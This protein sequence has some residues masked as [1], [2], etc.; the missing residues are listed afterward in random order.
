[1]NAARRLASA[2]LLSAFACL[3]V[4]ESI[5][6]HAHPL[7]DS[8]LTPH[9]LALVERTATCAPAAHFDAGRLGDHPVC[10]ECV[11]AASSIA[12]A[13]S[14]LALRPA[15]ASGRLTGSSPATMAGAA[16]THVD[17]ARGPPSA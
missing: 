6:F 5:A 11:L 17:G 3:G 14:A 15:G 9:H 10:A 1:M 13:R 2:L 4:A 7:E 8:D 16:A 12:V